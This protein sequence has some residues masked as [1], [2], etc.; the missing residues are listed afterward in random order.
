ME[1]TDTVMR[2]AKSEAIALLADKEINILNK[3]DVVV[4]WGGANDVNK[5]KQISNLN[6]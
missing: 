6:T 3:E 2:R 4:M 5:K 1:V